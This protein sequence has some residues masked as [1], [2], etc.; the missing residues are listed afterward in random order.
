MSFEELI[1]EIN[2]SKNVLNQLYTVSNSNKIL[3]KHIISTTRKRYSRS[4]IF[5]IKFKQTK[6]RNCLSTETCNNLLL[7]KEMLENSSCHKWRLPDDLI[8][9]LSN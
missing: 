4:Y 6:K 5:F 8:K 9:S 3:E 7:T 2:S 1:D